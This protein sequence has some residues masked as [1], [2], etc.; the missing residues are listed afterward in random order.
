MGN[1]GMITLYRLFLLQVELLA[2]LLFYC[3]V[4]EGS[5]TGKFT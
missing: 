5:I 3:S 1:T 2:G 4:I